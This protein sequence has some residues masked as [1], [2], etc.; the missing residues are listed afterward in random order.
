[1]VV[2]VVA[3]NVVVMTQLEVAAVAIVEYKSK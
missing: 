1:M 2:V 3:F